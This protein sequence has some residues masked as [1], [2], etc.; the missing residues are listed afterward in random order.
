LSIDGG[1][2]FVVFIAASFALFVLVLRFAL[3]RRV[4]EPKWGWILAI[5]V[6]VVPGGMLF[7]RWGANVELAWWVYYTAPALVTLVVPPVA[8]RMA[9]IEVMEY[10]LLAFLMAP[11]IH[12]LFSF[13]L[14]WKEYIPFLPVPSLLELLGRAAGGRS[15][16]AC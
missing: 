13:F 5:A 6:L 3:R 9:R 14:G 2:R 12:I 4:A 7:A 15:V 8:F 1:S 16:L 10:L 11:A